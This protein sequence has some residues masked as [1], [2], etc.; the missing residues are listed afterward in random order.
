MKNVC[1]KC[2][3]GG[4]VLSSFMQ[5]VARFSSHGGFSAW[6]RRPTYQ[7]KKWMQVRGPHVRAF[8]NGFL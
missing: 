7:K 3:S 2:D 1:T 8:L 6:T 4:A 5:H